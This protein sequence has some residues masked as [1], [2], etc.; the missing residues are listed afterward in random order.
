[1]NDQFIIDLKLVNKEGPVKAYADLTITSDRGEI[2]ISGFKVIQKD[3][4][5][6]F[7]ALPTVD[8]KENPKEENYKRVP[9]ASFSRLFQNFITDSILSQYQNQ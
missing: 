6:P 2:T 7:V 3:G 1:M 4:K 9:K 5:E 8:Y